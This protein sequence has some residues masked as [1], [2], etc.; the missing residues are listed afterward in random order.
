MSV[1]FF[2]KPAYVVRK[3]APLATCQRNG[4]ADSEACSSTAIPPELSFE[5]II[6]NKCAPPC[7]LQDFLD[8]LLYVDQSAENLQFYLWMVDYCHRW[9]SIPEAERALSPKWHTSKSTQTSQEQQRQNPQ[10]AKAPLNTLNLDEHS[11]DVSVASPGELSPVESSEQTTDTPKKHTP[12]FSWQ[13]SRNDRPQQPYRNEFNRIANHYITPGSPRELKL[14]DNDRVLLLRGLEY[15]TDPSSLSLIKSKLDWKLRNES[16]PNF[17]RWSICNGNRQWTWG[18]RIFA[19]TNITLG[20]VIAIVLILSHASRYWRILAAFEWWFGITNIIAASQG[21]CVLLHRMGTRQCHAWETDNTS[22][23]D[24]EAML[25][26]ADIGYIDYEST[27]TRWPVKMEVFGPANNFAGQ[28]WVSSY[29]R[30]PW[31]KKLFERRLAVHEMGLRSIQNRM[32][33]QAEAWALLITIPLTVA[34]VAIPSA[35]IF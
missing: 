33:R 2:K 25:K 11:E 7:S 30:R 32:I 26:G 9:K 35:N 16:H 15:T 6:C 23:D 34:F 27:K 8:Y 18:L 28:P 31:Y 20:F 24:D 29:S 5:R 3:N 4:G 12:K 1:L 21:L 14:S 19:A 13:S 17:I 10:E 22:L